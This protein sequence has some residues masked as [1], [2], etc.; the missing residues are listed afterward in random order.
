MF[1]GKCLEFIRHHLG[2]TLLFLLV[3]IVVHASPAKPSTAAIASAHP[4][5]TAAG[6]N[7]LRQ[8]GNA[9]DAAVAITAALAVVEPSGSGLGG[10]GFY[11]LHEVEKNRTVMLDAREK[12]PLEAHRDMYLTP[13]GE[14]IKYASLNGPLAAGIPGIPAA[15]EY[16]AK[17]YGNLPLSSSLAPAI[18]YATNG[19]EVSERYRSKLK[20]R[21]K[22]IKQFPS[23]AAIFLDNHQLPKSGWIL[24]QTDLA[25]TLTSLAN[26]GSK[27]FY[28]GNIGQKLVRE[29]RKNGGIWQ[30]NDLHK[31]SVI[32]REP[33]R[34]TYHGIT[35]TSAAPPS[36]GGIAL[37]TILNIL[38]GYD[39]EHLSTVK[40][41]HLIVE[42]MRR[43]YRDRAIYLG[44]PDFA[45]IPLERLTHPHY[46]AG[47]RATI[48]SEKATPSHTLPGA[49]LEQEGED[50]SHFSVID[51]DGNRVAAT[52]SI[53]L[54]FGSGYVAEGTGVLLNNEMDDFSIKPG[55]PNAYG[56]IGT[57]I[58]AIA[59]EKRPLSSMSPTFL[60]TKNRV[61][62]LGTPGGSRIITMVLHGILAFSKNEPVT[63]WVTRPRYHHQFLPDH[64]QYEKD[65]FSEDT[66]HQ[67]RQLGHKLKLVNR[68]YGDMQAILWEKSTNRVTAASDPRGVGSV[69]IIDK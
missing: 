22:S 29:V 65:A 38:E 53:N 47:L 43:A 31:Y 64:I 69:S 59:P 16:L 51:T 35:V 5:A 10:G 42:A 21:L 37:A 28:R 61:A 48:H 6:E 19:F 40:R 41:I 7:I 2:P 57:E 13:Q 34:T 25:N 12:A 44:D 52:L 62:L 55:I 26:E 50:T 46:A 33:I 56:L 24:T 58:N 20:W 17:H 60:E 67:L 23:T 9:F 18:T 39:L 49:H 45:D 15:L 4:L 63:S 68:R 36:S 32:E 3:P 27:V 11:L 8:G 1:A 14:A 66:Q 30:I 54:P